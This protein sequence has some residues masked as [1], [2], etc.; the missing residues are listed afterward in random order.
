MLN[1]KLQK[2]AQH[3]GYIMKT[4]HIEDY[5]WVGDHALEYAENYGLTE[6]Q[7]IAGV[8]RPIRAFGFYRRGKRMLDSVMIYVGS[9]IYCAVV[10]TSHDSEGPYTEVVTIMDENNGVRNEKGI[11][12]EKPFV[13]DIV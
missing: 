9:E 4:L 2:V 1:I 7:V 8:R 13:I 6:E 5:I 12:S 3:K 10:K 11:S